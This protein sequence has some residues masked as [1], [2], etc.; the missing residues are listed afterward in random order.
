MM[1]SAPSPATGMSIHESRQAERDGLRRARRAMVFETLTAIPLPLTI[2]LVPALLNVILIPVAVAVELA[3]AV[4]RKR[5]AL[6][7]L[8][9]GLGLAIVT[10]ASLAEVKVIDNIVMTSLPTTPT[11]IEAFNASAT[12]K[13]GSAY[14]VGAPDSTIMVRFSR[15]SLSLRR[16]ADELAAQTGMAAR[17]GYCGNGGSILF[18]MSPMGGY[19]D[20]QD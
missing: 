20:L 19:V 9:L 10:A 18:G 4:F 5:P 15:D 7:A 8:R 11:T 14:R 16:F 13:H 3:V 2:I 6:L 12:V 1:N 17:I